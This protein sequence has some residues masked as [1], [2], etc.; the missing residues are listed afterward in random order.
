MDAILIVDDEPYIRS[1][2]TALLEKAG[3]FCQAAE[4]VAQAKRLLTE[5][6][7]DLLITDIDMPGETGL[8]LIRHTK[9]R[10]PE[11]AVVIASVLDDPEQVKE[12]IDLGI[13]GYI[14][15]PFTANLAL[16]TVENALRRQRLELQEQYA[17]R[18]LEREVA[19]RT[20]LLDEQ[21]YFLQTLL[22]AIPVPIYYKDTQCVY[23]GCNRA[24][25]ETFHRRRDSVIGKTTFD[26][27]QPRLA[28]ELHAMDLELLQNRG[29]QVDERVSAHADGSL[30]YSLLHKATFNDSTGELAGL[31]GIGL[32]ITELKQTE[33]SL[34]RSEEKLRSIMDNLH[35]GVMM[36]SPGMEI[37]QVNKQMRTWFPKTMAD[38]EGG[39]LLDFFDQQGREQAFAEF[40]AAAVFECG[41]PQEATAKF[42]TADSER[43]FRV[44]IS[45]IFAD[46][47]AITAAVG[48]LE[49][50]TA[51]LLMEQELHQT[52]KLEA[53]GQLAA[54]IAH[55]INTPVQYVG[56]NLRFL[57]DSFK[58]ITAI[59]T[60]AEQL[61][62]ALK[63]NQAAMDLAS[64]LEETIQRADLPFF[65]DEIPKTI[66]QSMDGIN[67]VGAIV[68]AMREFSHPGSEEKVLVDI[69]HALENTLTVSRNEWKYIAETETDLAPDLPMLLCL[70]GEINQV[71]L[72][73]IVNATHAIADVTDGGRKGKGVI[74]LSTRIDGE[75]MEI[76]IADTGGGIPAAIQHRI[77]EPFFTTKK[78]GKGT[79]QGLALARNVVV[80]KHQGKLR[81]ETEPGV[82]TTFIVQLPLR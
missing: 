79:G 16:I 62:Q 47:G 3:H 14:L 69:N 71:L 4:N 48:L 7:F 30:K 51:K 17:N 61:A 34:R 54:G 46:G 56:D 63:H 75:W 82:G 68:R 67:R 21:L 80:D 41:T 27:H 70:P 38:T 2:L 59:C 9:T 5:T 65:L 57:S 11:V 43:I 36:I 1:L 50:V 39:N 55:E 32:D 81:F 28:A 15:K 53:I 31:V 24:F 73:I 40:S 12:I 10:Y 60:C 77:F 64:P 22:D 44:V 29:A 52:Q 8:D 25:E 6:P 42:N 45:P 76:R 58:D 13:Y 19:A 26:V 20:R 33:H 74:R 72:N 35:I 37:L 78:I 23:L 18:L 49:D 66:E